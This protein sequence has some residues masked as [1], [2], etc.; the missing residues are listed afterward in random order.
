MQAHAAVPAD[1][2]MSQLLLV[3][4]KGYE[5]R[6]A[7]SLQASSHAAGEIDRKAP[8]RFHHTC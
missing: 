5:A 8:W 1:T 4:C 3:H 7:C 6:I 2:M